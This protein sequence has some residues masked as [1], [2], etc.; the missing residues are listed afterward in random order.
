MQKMNECKAKISLICISAIFFFMWIVYGLLEF[1]PFHGSV[2]FYALPLFLSSISL[3]GSLLFL[4]ELKTRLKRWFLGIP[5]C[6]LFLIVLI[7]SFLGYTMAIY[8]LS[9]LVEMVLYTSYLLLAPCSVLFF[10]SFPED[11]RKISTTPVRISLLISIYSTLILPWAFR[12][13]ISAGHLEAVIGAVVLYCIIGMPI[14][15][16]CVVA[17]AIR[18]H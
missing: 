16:M 13:F 9:S 8:T 17:I 2:L 11:F 7:A 18:V 5:L 10:L 3:F 12:D 1:F 6:I 14:I 15:G 4:L